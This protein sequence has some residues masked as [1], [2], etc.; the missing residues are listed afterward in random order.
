MT[1]EREREK[2]RKKQICKKRKKR[3]TSKYWAQII[4]TNCK[5]YSFIILQVYYK[6][7]C[8]LFLL[9]RTYIST[10]SAYIKFF[11]HAIKVLHYFQFITGDLLWLLHIKC[12]G[13]FI[14]YFYTKFQMS[15]SKTLLVIAPHV[16]LQK[17]LVLMPSH[18]IIF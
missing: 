9:C 6:Y 5:L 18:Y 2:W 13:M 10:N 14:V 12:M 16:E 11:G 17:I 1:E 3:C 4:K 15:D 8:C 7:Y